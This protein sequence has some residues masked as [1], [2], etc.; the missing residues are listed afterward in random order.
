MK[1][2]PQTHKDLP[3]IRTQKEMDD[4]YKKAWKSKEVEEW[5]SKLTPEQLEF[6]EQFDTKQKVKEKIKTKK[7]LSAD[8]PDYNTAC[9]QALDEDLES[10]EN[11]KI[12]ESTV[13]EFKESKQ[14]EIQPKNETHE[15][16]LSALRYIVVILQDSK[17]RSLEVDALAVAT[18]LS[19]GQGKTQTEFA[20]N[21]GVSKQAFNTRVHKHCKALDLPLPLGSKDASSHD[22]YSLA[23]NRNKKQK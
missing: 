11:P 10:E 21:H 15:R 7:F 19:I 20:K 17:K 8:I 3:P 1:A 14:Q 18:G 13:N 6:A 4:E 22:S 5:L 12:I 2:K 16:Y 23:N 9:L